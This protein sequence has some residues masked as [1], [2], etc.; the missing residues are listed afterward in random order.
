MGKSDWRIIRPDWISKD[1]LAS[2]DLFRRQAFKRKPCRAGALQEIC[3]PEDIGRPVRARRLV[4]VVLENGYWDR[5]NRAL[6]RVIQVMR[7]MHELLRRRRRAGYPLKKEVLLSCLVDHLR[8]ARPLT[9]QEI[10]TRAYFRE[11]GI[12]QESGR[13]RLTRYRN[14]LYLIL[15]YDEGHSEA[16]DMPLMKSM[17]AS[18]LLAEWLTVLG[19]ALGEKTTAKRKRPPKIRT[20][21]DFTKSEHRTGE[22]VASAASSIR[23]SLGKKQRKTLTR[24]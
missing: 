13:D 17:E 14:E 15:M 21:E 8:S 11:K 7:S 9:R 18:E 19:V 23:K 20:L 3:P 24:R 10:D 5:E 1:E 2:R 4:E 22:Y 6:I 12:Y 16:N